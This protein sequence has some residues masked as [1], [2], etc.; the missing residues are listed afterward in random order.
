MGVLDWLDR[1]D[2][3]SETY[4]EYR[5]DK[6]VALAYLAFYCAAVAAQYHILAKFVLGIENPWF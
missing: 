5:F 1:D 4:G 2:P 6:I 3:R